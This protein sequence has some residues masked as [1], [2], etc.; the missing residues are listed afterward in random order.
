MSG[1]LFPG[2]ARSSDRRP[3]APNYP[4][5]RSTSGHEFLKPKRPKDAG[6]R[7]GNTPGNPNGIQFETPWEIWTHENANETQKIFR[8][9]QS[10][11]EMAP[12]EYYLENR[13]GGPLPLLLPT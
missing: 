4:T 2:Q 7:A 1:V 5:S 13:R 6:F 11:V 3:L 8:K 10:E 12:V 9:G